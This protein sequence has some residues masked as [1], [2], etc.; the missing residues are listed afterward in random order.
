M[1]PFYWVF[2]TLKDWRLVTLQ[3]MR[4]Q[5]L[6]RLA[7]N[8]EPE[9]THSFKRYKRDWLF[10]GPLLIINSLLVVTGLVG[11][12]LCTWIMCVCFGFVSLCCRPGRVST[13]WYGHTINCQKLCQILQLYYDDLWC[14]STLTIT[15]VSMVVTTIGLG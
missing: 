4:T 1:F 11:I 12:V 14:L 2:R 13:S 3:C 9:N 7:H 5:G 10:Q 6:S 15:C 8:L